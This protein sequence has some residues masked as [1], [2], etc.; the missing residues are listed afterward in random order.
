MKPLLR[1]FAAILLLAAVAAA[2]SPGVVFRTEARL[3]EIYA[4]IL[5]NH[6]RYLDDLPREDFRILDNGAPQP[7]ASFENGSTELSCAI[8]LDTTA[9]MTSSL[10]KVKSAIYRLIDD[11]RQSD[12]IAVYGFTGGLETLQDFTNDKAAAKKAVSRTRAEGTTALFD[13]IAKVAGETSRRRGK[14]A[15]IVF[16]DGDD[17]ASVLNGS[18]SVETARRLGI[19]LYT[20]A[21]G[22]ALRTPALLR[23]L[24]NMAAMTGG[25]AYMIDNPG[26]ATAIFDDISGGLRH[27]YFLAYSP[28]AAATADW[29]HIQITL[30][31]ISHYQVHAKEGYFP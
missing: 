26:R 14:K 18:R 13:A 12:S 9:S 25:K 4:T 6:G 16:T 19:P 24:K 29:R 15:V 22:E 21:A 31:G 11:F 10:P 1:F 23:V 17:N 28:P 3:V 2:Q 5:D 20:A 30:E 27:T 7:I 8:L